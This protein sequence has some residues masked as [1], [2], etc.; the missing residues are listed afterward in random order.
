M[1]LVLKPDALNYTKVFPLYDFKVPG[2]KEQIELA[3]SMYQ[4]LEANGKEIIVYSHPRKGY[5]IG[6]Y[7]TPGY[8][9]LIQ[10]LDSNKNYYA[11]TLYVAFE[12]HLEDFKKLAKYL[13]GV[14]YGRTT[15]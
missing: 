10:S 6:V 3:Q 9:Y 8:A 4:D 11:N 15:K 5:R 7:T 2:E 1:R 14:Y 12:S 13:E